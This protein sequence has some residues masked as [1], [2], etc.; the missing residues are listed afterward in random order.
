MLLGQIVAISFATNLFFPTLLL[1]P[2]APAASSRS[3]GPKWLGPWLLNLLA[4]LATAYPA[5]QLADEHYWHRPTHFMP[6]LLAPHIAL[7]VLPVARAIVPASYFQDDAQFTDKVYNYMWALV[8]GNAGL[9]LAWTTATAYSYSGFVRIRSALLEHPAVS[10]V[11]FDVVFCW[12]TWICWYR[13]QAK[14]VRRDG[15][16]HLDAASTE[17]GEDGQNT[18]LGAS[19]YDS[20][21]RRR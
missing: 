10:S 21:I 2:P 11:G 8:L 16:K 20:G 13:T 5:M 3:H 12:I 9:M 17:Y 6:V 1:S 19:S 15:A 14:P 4:I 7:T 18:A